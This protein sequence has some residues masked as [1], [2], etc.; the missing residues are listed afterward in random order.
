MFPPPRSTPIDQAETRFLPALAATAR[1]ITPRHLR[2]FL[3]LEPCQYG[4][5]QFSDAH[6]SRVMTTLGRADAATNRRCPPC[7]ESRPFPFMKPDYLAHAF[8]RFVVV[9]EKLAGDVRKIA[10]P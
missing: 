3:F 5:A 6:Q 7:A 4:F 8:T 2:A 9:L 10:V 1:T